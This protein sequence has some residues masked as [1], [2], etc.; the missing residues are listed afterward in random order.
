V[1]FERVLEERSYQEIARR[2]GLS[3]AAVKVKV[4]RARLKLMLAR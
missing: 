2:N 1:F 3:V 4:Y